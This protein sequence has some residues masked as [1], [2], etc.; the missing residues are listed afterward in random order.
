MNSEIQGSVKAA[1]IYRVEAYG[2][3]PLADLTPWGDFSE[4][5]VN[6]AGELLVPVATV[7]D[8][9]RDVPQRLADLLYSRPL[10]ADE[11]HNLVVTVGLNDL[12]DKTFKASAYTAAHYVGLSDGAPTFA[13][14]DTM[15]S[16][17]GWAEVEDYSQGARPALTLG[18]VAAGSVDNAASKATFSINGTVTVGGAFVTTNNTKGGDTGTLYGGGA[19]TEGNRSLINGDSLAIQVTLTAAAA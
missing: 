16:H 4:Y 15:A 2:P 13:A 1:T 9:V 7:I 6:R 17:A 11:F 12:L 19:L 8:L 10:W 3:V 18:T 14:G 5:A